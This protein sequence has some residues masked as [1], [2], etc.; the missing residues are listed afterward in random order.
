MKTRDTKPRAKRPRKSLPRSW[1]GAEKAFTDALLRTFDNLGLGALVIL[2]D[3]DKYSVASKGISA[4]LIADFI[5]HTFLDHPRIYQGVMEVLDKIEEGQQA[6]G[7]GT[8]H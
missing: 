3:G 4:A 1:P 7:K 2:Q 5:I 8:I 6:M